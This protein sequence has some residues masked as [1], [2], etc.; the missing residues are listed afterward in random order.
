MSTL[1]NLLTVLAS[2][3]LLAAPKKATKK[4]AKKAPKK[5]A[6]KAPKKPAKKAPKKAATPKP[7]PAPAEPMMEPVA[8]EQPSV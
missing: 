7:A 8:T 2:P 3:L 6:K 5:A 4:A 1:E